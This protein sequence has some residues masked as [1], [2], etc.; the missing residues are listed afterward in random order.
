MQ[1]L[2]EESIE[3]SLK[4]LFIIIVVKGFLY[5]ETNHNT[6]LWLN[7][8]TRINL[9]SLTKESITWLFSYWGKKSKLLVD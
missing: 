8:I 9:P 1:V 7:T 4:I 5:P 3:L 2:T 6:Q